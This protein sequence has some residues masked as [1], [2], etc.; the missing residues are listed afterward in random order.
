MINGGVVVTHAV[1]PD[2]NHPIA[3]SQL[4]TN[5]PLAYFCDDCFLTPDEA[6]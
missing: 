5:F 3:S 1:L 4:C 2:W 6:I